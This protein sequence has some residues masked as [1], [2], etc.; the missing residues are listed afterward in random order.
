MEC[1]HRELVNERFSYLRKKSKKVKQN[2][3][4]KCL[5]LSPSL[6]GKES[7]PSENK[8]LIQTL[9]LEFEKQ[10]GSTRRDLNTV[11]TILGQFQK[12]LAK[13]IENDLHI[14]RMT[15]VPVLLIDFFKSIVSCP[16]FELPSVLELINAH[17]GLLSKLFLL[18]ENRVSFFFSNRVT[19]LADLCLWAWSNMHRHVLCLNFLPDVFQALNLL[20]KQRLFCHS[21]VIKPLVVEY[22]IYSGLLFKIRQKFFNYASNNTLV[23]NPKIALIAL[24]ALGLMDTLTAYLEGNVPQSVQ[25][26]GVFGENKAVLAN[27]AK[28]DN[29][30]GLLK[31]KKNDEKGALEVGKKTKDKGKEKPKHKNIMSQKQSDSILFILN[32]TECAGCLH[33]LASVLLSK[34]TSLFFFSNPDIDSLSYTPVLLLF[35]PNFKAYIVILYLLTPGN[36]KRNGSKRLPQI[37]VSLSNLTLRVLNNLARFNLKSLQNLLSQS[38]NRDQFYHICTFLYDF[39]SSNYDKDQEAKEMLKQ[40]IILTGYF[41]LGNPHNQSI[42]SRGTEVQNIVFKLASL[43]YQFYFGHSQHK[44]LLFPTLLAVCFDSPANLKILFSEI[45]KVSKYIR[46]FKGLQI[47]C[48]KRI[49]GTEADQQIITYCLNYLPYLSLKITWYSSIFPF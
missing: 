36:F 26:I 3:S 32:E 22:I 19:S 21:Q 39:S 27:Q 25:N 33:L 2:L 28:R 10:L 9:A 29:T 44:D 12:I 16:K 7:Y 5:H 48:S 47:A 17:F 46:I 34:G 20:L 6:T 45:N 1:S 35:S 18:R 41:A 31:D 13:N 40:L 42:L 37:S 4:L 15:K 43:P 49:I 23:Q 30:E 14:A 11:A 8:K 24:K 38:F